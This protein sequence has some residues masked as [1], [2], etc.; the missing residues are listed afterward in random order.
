MEIIILVGKSGCGKTEIAKTVSLHGYVRFEASRYAASIHSNEGRGN[1]YFFMESKNQ[2]LV[3]KKVENDMLKRKIDKAVISGLRMVSEIKYFK[4][5]YENTRVV[6]VYASD[7]VCYQRTML[8]GSR[9]KFKSLKEFSF[10]RLYVGLC[11][12]LRLHIL[13]DA[14][15]CP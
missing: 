10:G 13:Q 4:E 5:K 9:K 6:G 11:S 3:A 7:V 8:R 12:R 2:T 15:L 1:F 14:G